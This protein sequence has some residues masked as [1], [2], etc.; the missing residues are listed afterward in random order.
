MPCY[1]TLGKSINIHRIINIQI[2]TLW[3]PDVMNLDIEIKMQLVPGFIWSEM[4]QK[5]R[6]KETQKTRKTSK[7]KPKHRMD[8]CLAS[9]T[10]PFATAMVG[11]QLQEAGN[12]K[13]VALQKLMLPAR[14]L[15]SFEATPSC[16]WIL[17]CLASLTDHLLMSCFC[18]LAFGKYVMNNWHIRQRR[19]VIWSR[20]LEI[21]HLAAKTFQWSWHR[22]QPSPALNRPLRWIN[23]SK[24]RA[25]QRRRHKEQRMWQRHQLREKPNKLK[26]L[27][28]RHHLVGA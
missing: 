13:I 7:T 28:L 15:L 22:R 17:L 1:T 21:A 18:A 9:E 14:K 23:R 16:P 2:S 12:R 11:S 26:L 20:S 10:M 5:P 25:R 8:S 27:N 4:T 19:S 24:L 6:N 3:N